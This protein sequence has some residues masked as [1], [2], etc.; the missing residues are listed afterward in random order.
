MLCGRAIL[1]HPWNGQ[2]THFICLKHL[3]LGCNASTKVVIHHGPKQMSS[4][5]CPCS[6]AHKPRAMISH[7]RC[8]IY[9]G[10]SLA[11]YIYVDLTSETS[12]NNIY[13]SP[14]AHLTA[15]RGNTWKNNPTSLPPRPG[16][17]APFRSAEEGLAA[18]STS[19]WWPSLVGLLSS[20]N[21]RGCCKMLQ[22]PFAN[23][24][25]TCILSSPSAYYGP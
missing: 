12:R 3:Q 15:P 23:S 20:N 18:V 8:F 14:P 11:S 4:T 13:D 24:R 6:N 9:H 21:V 25:S 10:V 1:P 2:C 19:D 5:H 7:G 16:G 22:I 17:R